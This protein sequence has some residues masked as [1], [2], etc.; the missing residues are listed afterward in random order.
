MHARSCRALG[1][2]L[3]PE[4]VASSS[5]ASNLKPK[6]RLRLPSTSPSSLV[7]SPPCEVKAPPNASN[8]LTKDVPWAWP[9]MLGL[10]ADARQQLQTRHL[11]LRSRVR[12]VRLG[13]T[14]SEVVWG[15]W[16]TCLCLWIPANHIWCASRCKSTRAVICISATHSTK[17]SLLTTDVGLATDTG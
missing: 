14:E 12:S 2:S 13:C 16:S 9:L 17:I 5:E 1:W 10:T 11:E 7:V 8:T 3:D 15:V 6:G 4:Y